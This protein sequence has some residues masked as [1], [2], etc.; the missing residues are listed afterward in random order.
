MS[1][2]A[3]GIRYCRSISA[4]LHFSVAGWSGNVGKVSCNQ[5]LVLQTGYGDWPLNSSNYNAESMEPKA[6]IQ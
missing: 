2:N 1:G 4:D 3:A 5:K 6:N